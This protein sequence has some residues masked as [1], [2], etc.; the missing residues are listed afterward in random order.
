MQCKAGFR[1]VEATGQPSVVEYPRIPN[2]IKG[3][4]TYVEAPPPT[5]GCGGPRATIPSL[6]SPKSCPGAVLII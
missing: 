5:P 2:T 1:H 4:K 3:D 6:P